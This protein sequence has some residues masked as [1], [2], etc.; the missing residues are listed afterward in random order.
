MDSGIQDL[1]IVENFELNTNDN[2]EEYD[3]DENTI[4]ILNRY[5]DESDFDY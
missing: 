2:F 3:E 4:S 1:K 5:I